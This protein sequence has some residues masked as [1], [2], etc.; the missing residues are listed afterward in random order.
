MR[1]MQREV[2]SYRDDNEKIM[3]FREDILEILNMFQRQPNKD[4]STKK[5]TSARQV[6]ASI[7]HKRRDDHGNEK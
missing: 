5:A 7:S 1:S 4:S 3:K 6:T 2:Q